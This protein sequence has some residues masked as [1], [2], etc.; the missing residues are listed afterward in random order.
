MKTLTLLGQAILRTA[1]L[2]ISQI[3]IVSFSN[4]AMNHKPLDS[5]IQSALLVSFTVL[6]RLSADYARNGKITQDTIDHAIEEASK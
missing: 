1:A 4:M 2:S 3:A 5:V 6:H